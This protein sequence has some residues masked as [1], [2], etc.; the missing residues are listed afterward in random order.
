MSV[1]A[2]A[3]LMATGCSMID[4]LTGNDLA[5]ELERSGLPARAVVLEIRETGVTVNDSPVVDFLLEV[6]IEGRPPYQAE[7]KAL[8]SILAIPR[9]Q[10]GAELA[11]LYDPKD[12][13]RVAIG[14]PDEPLPTLDSQPDREGAAATD[15]R[16][17]HDLRIDYVE[18]ETTD[19]EQ[20]KAFYSSVFGWSFTD[21][22]PDYASF[23]DGRLSGG[24]R[25]VE[26]VSKSGVL[27]VIY[28]VDLERAQ[29]DVTAHGGS[30][31]KE[32]F[33]F[34]GGRRFRFSDPT[35]IILAVWSDR[36]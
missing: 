27:L 9:I 8:V 26:A 3:W 35:G 32:I 22:G 16:A 13:Q 11:V 12:P 4:S 14:V 24:F 17:E 6:H 28:A 33:D 30:I 31:V 19:I 23:D 20:S 25:S 21:W 18:L 15:S 7:A 29:S 2:V 36:D 34:P 5:R 1:L 10:P